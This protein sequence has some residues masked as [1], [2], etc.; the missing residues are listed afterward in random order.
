MRYKIVYTGNVRKQA[1]PGMQN[2]VFQPEMSSIAKACLEFL[3][4]LRQLHEFL[5]C[6]GIYVNA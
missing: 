1:F 5:N 4:M 6:Q 2:N 3:Q